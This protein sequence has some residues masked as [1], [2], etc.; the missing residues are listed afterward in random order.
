MFE[1]ADVFIFTLG[2]TESWCS[3]LDGAVFPACPGSGLGGEYDP[4][5]HAFRNFGMADVVSH[6]DQFLAEL[7]EVNPAVQVLL[8]VSPVPLMATFE[9]RHVLQSTV[10][11]KSV[12]RVAAEELVRRHAHVHYFASYEIVTA[13]G[14]SAGYFLDDRRSVSDAA[15]AH[16]LSC[17]RQQFTGGPAPAAAAPASASGTRPPAGRK[18]LCDEE[19]KL[20]ALADQH[21]EG[22]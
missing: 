10:Y 20:A 16:V 14:D 9:P 13:T 18:P 15:V 11:S 21:R 2:L 5:R 7:A 6:M 1:R 19:L 17:F 22:A 8:T 4:A 12:L 3:T